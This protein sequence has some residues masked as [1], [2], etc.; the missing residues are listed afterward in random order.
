M[1]QDGKQVSRSYG[2]GGIKSIKTFAHQSQGF[3][4]QISPNT[5]FHLYTNKSNTILFGNV[6]QKKTVSEYIKVGK[7]LLYRKN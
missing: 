2:D 5:N 3:I 7:V 4:L 1:Y 6:Y